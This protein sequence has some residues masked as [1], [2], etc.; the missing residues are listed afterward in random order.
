LAEAAGSDQCSES[1]P[2]T[3]A[4]RFTANLT[5]DADALKATDKIMDDRIKNPNASLLS[6]F[7]KEGRVV[8]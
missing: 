8:A 3:N 6:V 7:G 2:Q 5:A 1:T 4:D